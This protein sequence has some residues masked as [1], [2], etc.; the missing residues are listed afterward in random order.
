MSGCN[1]RYSYGHITS[2]GAMLNC[3]SHPIAKYMDAAYKSIYGHIQYTMVRGLFWYPKGGFREWHTNRFHLSGWRLYM[4]DCDEDERSWFAY[5]HPK[6]SI[7]HRI[8]EERQDRNIR[9][10]GSCFLAQF[11]SRGRDWDTPAEGTCSPGLADSS[12]LFEPHFRF[13][14]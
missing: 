14:W 6:T 11:H 1:I 7:T 13:L 2:T 8:P 5:K 3:S 4:I 9:R 12:C 10:P